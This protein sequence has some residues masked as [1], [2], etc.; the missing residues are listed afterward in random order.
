M[1]QQHIDP[2]GVL[3]T[4]RRVV[5]QAVLV[6]I[7][8]DAAARVAKLLAAETAT[9]PGWNRDL[10]W[11][12]TPEQTANYL[13][14]LDALNFCFW[15]EP[16]WRVTY[17]GTRYDGYWALAAALKRALEAG[18]PLYD[19]AYLAGLDAA[20]LQQVFQGEHTIPLFD[21]RLDNTREVGRVLIERYG[22][23]FARAIEAAGGSATRLVEIVVSSFPSF[24]DT[25]SYK[26]AEVR[27]YKRAQI[28][29]SDLAGAFGG[30]G[31][32]RFNDLNRIT[33]FADYK[34]PQVLHALGILI[35]APA[36]GAVL[37]QQREIPA[38]SP[39]EVEIRAATI[40][41]VEEIRRQLA[42]LGHHWDAYRVDWAL[43]EMGQHLPSGVRPYHRTRTIAY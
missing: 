7:D 28:L 14:L 21:A 4:T 11:E 17:R 20:R 5:D 31:L 25:A 27:F 37:D 10:H 40:W 36:L 9:P 8:R 22:G 24:R 35:Y 16:R 15:G 3:E 30:T 43:W 1:I 19:A 12:G 39:E 32:G 29:A 2:L 34:V 38:G 23:Q 18:L 6:R 41:G 26:G 13:L 33:A 42:S